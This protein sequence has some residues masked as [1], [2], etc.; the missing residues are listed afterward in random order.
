MVSTYVASNYHEIFAGVY[1]GTGK[2]SPQ[3]NLA[4]FLDQAGAEG[5]YVLVRPGPSFYANGP[6]VEFPNVRLASADST[7]R[8]SR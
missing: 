5:S 4:G 7:R 2:I 8:F 3:R 1:D 6:A